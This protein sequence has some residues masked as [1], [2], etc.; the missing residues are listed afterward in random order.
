[1]RA[2]GWFYFTMKSKSRFPNCSCF[3]IQIY[4]PYWILEADDFTRGVGR[5]RWV[6]AV[7]RLKCLSAHTHTHTFESIIVA[8]FC[9]EFN[10]IIFFV[11]PIFLVSSPSFSSFTWLSLTRSLLLFL[12]LV[13]FLLSVAQHRP[14]PKHKWD[15]FLVDCM[16]TSFTFS[17]SRFLSLSLSLFRTLVSSSSSLPLSRPT[18]LIRQSNLPKVWSLFFFLFHRCR[19]QPHTNC[20]ST[21]SVCCCRR[22]LFLTLFDIH[23]MLSSSPLCSD[24]L[25]VDLDWPTLAAAH[26]H[27]KTFCC[28]RQLS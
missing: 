8:T 20:C 24:V 12:P 23:S 22:L 7:C 5:M 21:F 26:T 3:V 27:T 25:V 17:L 11:C 13:I 1:M 4:W 15:S 28:P 16:Q 19:H 18:N 14:T 9:A 6:L 10:P 2:R